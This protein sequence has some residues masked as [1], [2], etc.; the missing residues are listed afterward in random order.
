[1]FNG[2]R[3]NWTLRA[4]VA[5]ALC[6]ALVAEVATATP[7]LE[8]IALTPP[9][10]SITVGQTQPFTATGTFSNGTK[11]ELGPEVTGMSAGYRTT[12]ALLSSGGVEC[13]GANRHGDLGAG[14]VSARSLVARPVIGIE[15]ATAVTSSRSDWGH[16]CAL[17]ATGAVKCWGD[18]TSGELGNGTVTA[19]E[20]TP[21]TVGGVNTAIAV[22]VGLWHSC[23]LLANGTVQCW[24]DNTYGQLGDSSNTGYSS[25]PVTVTGVNTAV[26]IATGDVHTCAVL[27]S[28]ATKCWGQNT[29]G[30]LGNGTTSDSS[31]PTSVLGIVGA[32]ALAAGEA[33]TC[34]LLDSGAVQCWGG[35]DS[36]Q[37]GDGVDYVNST[38]PLSVSGVSTAVAIA[39]GDLHN[40]ALL[41]SGTVMCWGYNQFGQLGKNA[42]AA[43][44]SNIPIRIRGINAATGLA[45]G[46]L[47]SCALFS[48]GLMACW[49]ADFDGQLGNARTT[50]VKPNPSPTNVIGTPGV[51]WASSN[52]SKATI[53]D[54]GVATGHAAGNTTITATTAGLINDNAVLT[55][56]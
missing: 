16:S 19:E 29:F 36:G 47:H 14:F 26:S 44:K 40:C 41:R 3:I 33:H 53:T 24:G 12:C 10:P 31:T 46:G 8:S 49:G 25:T 38:S 20:S 45:S 6:V 7:K 54:R 56:K 21:V 27:A 4:R 37:L 5:T 28:G 23:A 48:G 15:A 34:A 22:A 42:G 9:A 55:V 13:W 2:N 1:M 43:Q 18:N 51:V 32:R 35:N 30:Q 39:A 52:A 50:G 11:Q 17:L